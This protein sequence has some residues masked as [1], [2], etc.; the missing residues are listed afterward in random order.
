MATH[1]EDLHHGHMKRL[2][3]EFYRG[4]AFVHWSMTIDG[5]RTGWLTDAFHL[6]FRFQKQAWDVVLG[7]KERQFGAVLKTAFY[8]AENPVRAGLVREAREW[9]FSGCQ[10]AGYPQFDWRE[11]D[12]REKI[13]RIYEAEA[14]R[15]QPQPNGAES[16]T[17]PR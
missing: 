2:S 1:R 13:W 10:A 5:R 8:V 17:I 11:P 16:V 7:E 15:R 4:Q 3:P 6:R 14:R 9:P 12:Y